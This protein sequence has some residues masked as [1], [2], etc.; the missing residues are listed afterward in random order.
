MPTFLS[1]CLKFPF[2]SPASDLTLS[3]PVRSVRR[4]PRLVEVRTRLCQ[5]QTSHLL[6]P[7][8][9]CRLPGSPEQ[10]LG[11]GLAALLSFLSLETAAA[12]NT[13]C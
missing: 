1:P 3:C 9:D 7:A 8:R 6:L 4:F 11:C 10:H 5:G 2:G 13:P 12:T